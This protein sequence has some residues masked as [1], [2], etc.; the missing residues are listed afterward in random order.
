MPKKTI[1]EKRIREISKNTGEV[2]FTLHCLQRMKE[3]EITRILIFEV[4]IKG[5][6][7]REPELDIRTGYIQC[8]MERFVAGRMLAVV[9]ALRNDQ[10]TAC[11]VVTAIVLRKLI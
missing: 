4:L 7:K 10:A 11:I 5:Q 3:R 8:R 1:L 9:V 6:I 2:N